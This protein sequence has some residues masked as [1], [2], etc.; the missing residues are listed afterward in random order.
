VQK[1]VLEW[2]TQDLKCSKCK[3]LRSNE[4]MEHCA[5]AG[6]WI[7]TKERVDVKKKLNTYNNVAGFYGLRMLE[8]VVQECL[9]G[10]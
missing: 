7:G 6:E 2:C 10:V 9:E 5:C 1:V 8:S 4:F 3:R